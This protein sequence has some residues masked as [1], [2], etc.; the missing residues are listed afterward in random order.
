MRFS[1]LVIF[2]IC[3]GI[4]G[5]LSGGA[6]LF[7]R[8]GSRRHRAAGNVFFTSMLCMSGSAAY[9]AAFIKPNMGNVFAGVLTFYLV[10]TG[11]LTVMRKERQTGLL[12]F[13]LLFIALTEGAGGLFFGW[14]V[15]NSAT[16]LKDGYPPA[17]YF[18][19]G[20]AALLLAAWDVRMLIRHGVSGARRIARHLWR[21]SL[22]LL[23]AALSFFLGQQ[24]VFPET[25]R[26][27]E[28]LNVPPTIVALVMIFWLL[29]VRFTNTFKKA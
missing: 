23:I 18:I 3:T 7:F 10:A 28:L 13:V 19:F 25:I 29:R 26:K 27:T 9:M 2:H 24:Q 12:E 11:W 5:L 22:A 6:A 16:G 8:K 20:S 17:F 14:E 15:A 4:V 21:M 1:P